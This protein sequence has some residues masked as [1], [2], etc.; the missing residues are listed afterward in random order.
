MVRIEVGLHDP[1]T[2]QGGGGEQLVQGGVLRVGHA[3]FHRFEQVAQR[4]GPPGEFDRVLGGR[5]LQ[6][7]HLAF[8]EGFRGHSV[9]QV[10]EEPNDHLGVGDTDRPGVH[11]GGG[12]RPFDE[13]FAEVHDLR[14]RT[15]SDARHPDNHDA[16]EPAPKVFAVPRVSR[17]ATR[18][19]RNASRSPMRWHTERVAVTSSVSTRRHASTPQGS[20]STTSRSIS[21]TLVLISVHVERQF[22]NTSPSRVANQPAEQSA[23]N[24]A[25]TRSAQWMRFRSTFWYAEAS[26]QAKTPRRQRSGGLEPASTTSDTSSSWPGASTFGSP[27]YWR[28]PT[29]PLSRSISFR[30][31]SP[32]CWHWSLAPSYHHLPCADQSCTGV[33]HGGVPDV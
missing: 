7:V 13:G 12:V 24:C 18:R 9:G 3:V 16:V 8:G 5:R 17:S 26:R 1:A 27:C 19:T 31:R 11:R 25:P 29:S 32:E 20:A 21:Q 4:C 15:R 23:D 2:T 33:L 6:Q 28:W 10:R 22:S 14:G 30:P